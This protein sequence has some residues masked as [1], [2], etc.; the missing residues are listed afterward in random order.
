MLLHSD[1]QFQK[2]LQEGPGVNHLYFG[3]TFSDGVRRVSHRTPAVGVSFASDLSIGRIQ[4]FHTPRPHRLRTLA[5][6][7]GPKSPI[8]GTEMWRLHFRVATSSRFFRS[9]KD[10]ASNHLRSKSMRLFDVSY[11][12]NFNPS[13]LDQYRRSAWICPH[14]SAHSLVEEIGCVFH[15]F[16]RS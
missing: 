11:F 2:T 1:V 6:D 5:L 4:S 10:T 3:P 12:S 9:M 16:I 8:P 14:P 7:H 15:S 13:P